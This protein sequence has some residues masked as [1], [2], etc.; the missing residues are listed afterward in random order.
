[1]KRFEMY[2]HIWIETSL[3]MFNVHEYNKYKCMYIKQGLEIRFTLMC[4]KFR[5]VIVG[6]FLYLNHLITI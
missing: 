5:F 3:K 6:K 4:Q 1:M 2:P